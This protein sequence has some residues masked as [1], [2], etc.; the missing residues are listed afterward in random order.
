M[1]CGWSEQADR[2][3]RAGERRVGDFAQAGGNAAV[4]GGTQGADREAEQRGHVRL[5]MPGSDL[6]V[7]LAERGASDVVH[8]LDAQ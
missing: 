1:W 7:V 2:V 5:P 3:E 6:R 4:R 8:G